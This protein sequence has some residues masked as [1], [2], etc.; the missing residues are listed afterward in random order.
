MM[1][2]MGHLKWSLMGMV[3][4]V[5][6]LSFLNY[7][8]QSE[9]DELLA[10]LHDHAKLQVAW[11]DAINQTLT[12]ET[13][14]DVRKIVTEQISSVQ[15]ADASHDF[16]Y[17]FIDLKTGAVIY[18]DE[19]VGFDKEWLD[20]LLVKED[21]SELMSLDGNRLLVDYTLARDLDIGIIAYGELS[22]LDHTYIRKLAITLL[23]DLLVILLFLYVH[24]V[25]QQ[26]KHLHSRMMDTLQAKS[27][28]L[29]HLLGWQ[30]NL[31]DEG[32]L[33]D[34]AFLEYFAVDHKTIGKLNDF[35][36]LLHP[37][38]LEMFKSQ[39]N[40][41]LLDENDFFSG[42]YHFRSIQGIISGY[43]EITARRKEDGLLADEVQG[44]LLVIDNKDL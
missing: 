26:N 12:E 25:K 23:V 15:L 21:Y 36:G 19:A 7:S 33:A 40:A 22:E 18:S 2:N 28:P 37:D 30:I 10:A 1:R 4:I 42:I 32:F 43:V 14:R 9:T 11:M 17:H 31:L 3:V 44:Y 8:Y 24:R 29:K 13:A 39:M 38:D 16:H 6:S 20:Q 5:L 34:S 41:L 35:Y 27:S